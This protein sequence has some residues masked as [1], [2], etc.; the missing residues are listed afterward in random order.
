MLASA[1]SSWLHSICRLTI[2]LLV[3]GRKTLA[4]CSGLFQINVPVFLLALIVFECESEDRAA[5][6]DGVF[7]LGVARK[8]F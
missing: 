7:A 6:L 3:G 5:L 4:D 8:S 2:G 1:F